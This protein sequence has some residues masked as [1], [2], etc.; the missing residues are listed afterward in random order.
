MLDLQVN[1]I[2]DFLS[3]EQLVSTNLAVFHDR[4]VVVLFIELFLFL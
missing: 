4:V 2:F 3:T 1:P